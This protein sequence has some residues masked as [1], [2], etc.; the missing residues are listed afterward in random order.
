M[1]CPVCKTE[2]DEDE[3]YKRTNG[4]K[5]SSCKDCSKT[6]SN[7]YYLKN[8]NII[9]KDRTNSWKSKLKSKYGLSDIEYDKMYNNQNGLCK[10]CGKHVAHRKLSVDHD[11]MSGKIR[12]LLCT[13]CNVRLGIVENVIRLNLLERMLDYIK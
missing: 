2:K 5:P 12:G 7:Q 13:S 8:K 1:R 3:F 10:L 9:K 11:H 6:K 4:K